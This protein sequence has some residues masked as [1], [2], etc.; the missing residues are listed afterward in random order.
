M[1]SARRFPPPWRAEK[2]PGG[3]V[4]RDASGQASAH[5]LR[6]SDDG[7]GYAGEDY[8]AVLTSAQ[9][10]AEPAAV[11]VSWQDLGFLIPVGGR[12]RPSPSGRGRLRFLSFDRSPPATTADN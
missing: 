4:V 6:E 10:Q 12:S 11:S 7:R 2:T 3:Y 1:T 8:R 9:E 5:I